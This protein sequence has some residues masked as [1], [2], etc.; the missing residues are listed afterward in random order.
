MS[1]IAGEGA[2]P[3]ITERPP[4]LDQAVGARVRALREAAGASR[5]DLARAI[6][7]AGMRW[8]AGRVAHM[9]RGRC[10]ASIPTLIPLAAALAGVSGKP[11]SLADLMP[12]GGDVTTTHGR[13]ISAVELW[14]AL[15]GMPIDPTAST[16]GYPHLEPG[17]GR[18]DDRL[19]AEL[20]V[21]AEQVRDAT[22]NLYGR[23]ATEER[24]DRAGGGATAQKRG[25]ITR[26]VLIEV[27][28]EIDRLATAA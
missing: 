27:R 7:R 2:E 11:V 6:Q 8:D 25:R 4:T 3:A 22:R 17:W 24:D 23:S 20:G 26:H 28:A 12:P 14:K 18:V 16:G 10:A 15:S 19:V 21:A 13:I 1:T 9:E 5:D